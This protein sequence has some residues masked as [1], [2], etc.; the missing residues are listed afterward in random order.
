MGIYIAYV[1]W[2]MYT[3]VRIPIWDKLMLGLI[4]ELADTSVW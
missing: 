1:E 2:L 4:D 3:S